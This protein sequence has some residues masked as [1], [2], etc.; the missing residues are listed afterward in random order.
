MRGKKQGAH[1]Q[2]LPQSSKTGDFAEGADAPRPNRFFSTL[3][4]DNPSLNA[5]DKTELNSDWH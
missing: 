2:L 3:C 5:Y 1:K 4:L